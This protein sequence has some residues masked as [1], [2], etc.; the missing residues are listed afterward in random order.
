MYHPGGRFELARTAINHRR[1]PAQRL[2]PAR[3]QELNF[4]GS[5]HVEAAF[6]MNVRTNIFSELIDL[7]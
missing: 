4:F 1:I 2:L 7:D 5:Q 6:Q 3:G